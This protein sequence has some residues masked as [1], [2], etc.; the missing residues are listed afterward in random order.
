MPASV[1]RHNLARIRKRMR[2][3]QAELA[4]LVGCSAATIKS[5]EIGKLALSHS[6]ATRIGQVVGIYDKDWLLK[7]DLTAPF[8]DYRSPLADPEFFDMDD[9]QATIMIE[10]FGR[11]FSALAKMK[12]TNQGLIVEGFVAL[13][14]DALRKEPKI[15]SRWRA[16]AGS[17]A[18]E[19][20]VRYP[21]LFDEELLKW[22]DLKGLLKSN[23][24]FTSQV[25]EQLE[26][27][28]SPKAQKLP[29]QNPASASP[30]GRR[31]TR[32]SS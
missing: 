23:L 5:V 15:D 6:L 31:K 19:F 18:I 13:E 10:L 22:V 32:A 30:A 20:F 3:T 9:A 1:A 21:K 16:F 2:L 29:S 12:G 27:A 4:Q 7:N 25:G 28:Q 14:M 8:P 24:Q 11:L 26:K 17:K